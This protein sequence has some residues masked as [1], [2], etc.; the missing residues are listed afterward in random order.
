M[1]L[2][3][4]RHTSAADPHGYAQD[5]DRPLTSSGRHEAE[6]MAHAMKTLGYLPELILSSPYLR[7]RE[8]AAVVAA[9][10]H[11]DPPLDVGFLLP[12]ADPIT[13]FADLSSR[14]ADSVLLVGHAPDLPQLVSRLCSGEET[15]VIEMAKGALAY[16]Q[17]ERPLRPHRALLRALIPQKAAAAIR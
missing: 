17:V 2:Y 13:L 14:R 5:A 8:T 9:S 11:L 16:L 4:L 7:A 6:Q 15:V 12:C 1:N 3:L 10:L